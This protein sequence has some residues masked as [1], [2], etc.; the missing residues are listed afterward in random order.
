M[1]RNDIE[2]VNEAMGAIALI[3][4]YY[5]SSAEGWKLC[6][7]ILKILRGNG[8]N[9]FRANMADGIRASLSNKTLELVTR[10]AA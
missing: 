4:D 2:A 5:A 7:E 8:E 9:I 6:E 10:R 3:C 1:N